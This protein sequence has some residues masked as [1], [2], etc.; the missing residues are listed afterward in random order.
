[1]LCV[2]AARRELERQRQ[3]E[4]ERQRRD[5][6]MAEKQREQALVDAAQADV[7]KMKLELEALVRDREGERHRLLVD[8]PRLQHRHITYTY[9]SVCESLIKRLCEIMTRACAGLEEV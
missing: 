7:A 3:L 2:Q 1:M 5:Q 8:Q 6:L 9:T 4:W